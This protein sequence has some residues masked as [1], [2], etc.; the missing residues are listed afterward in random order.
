MI[1]V[2]QLCKIVEG[3]RYTKSLSSKQRTAQIGAC[4]QG[5]QERQGICENAMNVSKYSSDKLIAG[6]GL[7]FENKLA[8]VTGRILPAPQVWTRTYSMTEHSHFRLVSGGSESAPLMLLLCEQLE[9]GNGR[10]EEPREGRWNFNNKVP[11][12]FVRPFTLHI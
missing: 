12:V 4:K 10:S 1:H 8:P 9:F 3:Q 11:L 5:P 2:L 6:F 7:Q